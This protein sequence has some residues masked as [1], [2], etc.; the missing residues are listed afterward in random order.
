MSNEDKK[1]KEE[2]KK[3]ENGLRLKRTEKIRL[4]KTKSSIACSTTAEDF[5][6]DLPGGGNVNS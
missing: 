4:P 3:G 1:S 6:F 2:K 5:P